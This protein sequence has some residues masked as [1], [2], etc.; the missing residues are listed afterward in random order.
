MP[1]SSKKSNVG[2]C[3]LCLLQANVWTWLFINLDWLNVSVCWHDESNTIGKVTFRHRYMN[4]SIT[5]V[6][7]KYLI[8]SL[9]QKL[10]IEKP[11]LRSRNK[12]V[13]SNDITTAIIQVY[14]KIK[15]VP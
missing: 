9:C 8:L 1:V 6:C 13:P 7:S 14:L 10:Q 2:D 4:P 11:L 12:T 5:D 3:S 15:N